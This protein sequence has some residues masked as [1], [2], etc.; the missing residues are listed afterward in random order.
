[1]TPRPRFTGLD[2]EETVG[3]RVDRYRK[4][5]EELAVKLVEYEREVGGM[6]DALLVE[7]LESYLNLGDDWA[8]VVVREIDRRLK[9]RS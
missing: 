2:V 5:R 8:D 3:E 1:M 6:S 7:E 9:E 4:F